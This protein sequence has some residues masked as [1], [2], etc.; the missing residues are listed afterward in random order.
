MF[1]IKLQIC[2]KFFKNLKR[3]QIAVM[4]LFACKTQTIFILMTD[5]VHFFYFQLSI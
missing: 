4:R 3:V 1:V 5:T 2:T